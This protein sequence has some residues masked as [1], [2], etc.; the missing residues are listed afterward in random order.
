MNCATFE[1]GS[2]ERMVFGVQNESLGTF[3][4]AEGRHAIFG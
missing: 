3:M 2:F 4:Q 1:A